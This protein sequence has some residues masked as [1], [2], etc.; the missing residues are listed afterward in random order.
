MKKRIG[1]LLV[2]IVVSLAAAGCKEGTSVPESSGMEKEMPAPVSPVQP[3]YQD[4]TLTYS[5]LAGDHS[6]REVEDPAGCRYSGKICGY[7]VSMG[8]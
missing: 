8:Q 7:A 4:G 5:N 3:D 2:A 1:G 6:Q